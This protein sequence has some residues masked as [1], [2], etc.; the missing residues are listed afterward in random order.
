[1]T[2]WY[3]VSGNGPQQARRGFQGVTSSFG[4]SE[5]AQLTYFVAVAESSG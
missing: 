5:C 4:L 2:T 1:M 3:Y